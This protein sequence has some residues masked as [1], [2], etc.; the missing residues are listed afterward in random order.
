M[1][2][3]AL[4]ARPAEPEEAGGEGEGAG[5]GEGESPFGDGDVVVGAEFADV[6]WVCE[7]DEDE[8]Y[9]FAGDHAEVGESADTFVEVVLALEDEGVGGEEEVE[10]AVDEGHVEADEEDDGF[11]EEDPDGA[12]DVFGEEFAQVDF[13]FFLFGV[14]APV[15]GAAAEG[16][17]FVDEDYGGVGFGEEEEEEGE[18][19]ETHDGGDVFGP[20]PAEGGD[21]DEAADLGGVS[22]VVFGFVFGTGGG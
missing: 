22:G 13:Y 5:D 15:F 17:G 11:A 20:A 2:A 6:A 21:G 1:D 3:G 4:V 16:A 12:G 9:E 7:H 14:D 19:G 10:E 18:C 8:G